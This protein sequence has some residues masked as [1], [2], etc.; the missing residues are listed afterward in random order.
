M[1]PDELPEFDYSLL[2][3]VDPQKVR[4]SSSTTFEVPMSN[5][6]RLAIGGPGMVEIA[7]GE[8]TFRIGEGSQ[9]LFD[10]VIVPA[11][12]TDDRATVAAYGD[13]AEWI[14]RAKN[15]RCVDVDLGNTLP[16]GASMM[17][18]SWT[19]EERAD[20]FPLVDYGTLFGLP[21]LT[22]IRPLQLY[23][24]VR[25]WKLLEKFFNDAG[26]TVR[27]ARG[28]SQLWKKL[29]T[30]YNGGALAYNGESVPELSVVVS[31]ATETRCFM[32]NLGGFFVFPI[33]FDTE[34]SDPANQYNLGAWYF[35][36]D[37]SG[38]V[39]YRMDGIFIVRRTPFT[40][41]NGYGSTVTF[42][43]WCTTDDA[44][45]ASRTYSVPT[46]EMNT[47]LSL[48]E[49]LFSVQ[50]EAGKVYSITADVE[51]TDG[52]AFGDTIQP[53][54]WMQ[55]GT[56]MSILWTGYDGYQMGIR[57]GVAQTMDK[58]LTIGKVVS[59]IVN[60]YRLAVH[61]NQLTNVVTFMFLDDY[62]TGIGTGVDWR[63]RISERTQPK[64]V[65]PQVPVR[66]VFAYN[67]DDKDKY[68]ERLTETRGTV[69]GSA[70]YR[71]GGRDNEVSVQLSFSPTA[72]GV[73][74]G[75]LTVPALKEIDT[76][77]VEYLKSKPRIL[78]FAG[79]TPGAWKFGE[80]GSAVEY[81][82]YPRS[83][84]SGN[85]GSDISM[86]F[87]DDHRLGTVSRYWKNFLRR[88]CEPYYEAD[89]RVF[90]DEFMNFE[91]GR[92]RLLPGRYGDTWFYVQKIKAKRF[93]DNSPIPCELIPL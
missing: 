75:G 40:A 59:D 82:S 38:T 14:N 76:E 37:L 3:I 2:E 50:V 66:Y 29:H 67:R 4:G 6:T 77:D 30:A 13:N 35:Q 27:A 24:G 12:W 86:N 52:S 71:S 41:A 80:S 36:P 58:G 91:F 42:K 25:I 47:S 61:T 89:V 34:D 93:G 18:D 44:L 15:T 65:N 32:P 43:L 20:L 74:L 78:T 56:R 92:P 88:S 46:G 87:G 5:A 21:A 70:E 49:V 16:L 45:V 28:F 19:D 55:P 26:F 39:N 85:G 53:R 68:T 1:P 54:L 51:P 60:I 64:K 83:Y 69:F 84:F 73:R 79:L 81:A 10:G 23:P 9:I 33:A 11:D 63:Q 31:C 57:V 7:P 17:V 62:L 8:Q 48:A 90:D 22:E 72:Q